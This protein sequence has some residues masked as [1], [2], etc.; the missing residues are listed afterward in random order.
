MK[1]E[2]LFEARIME[3]WLYVICNITLDTIPR[4]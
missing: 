2:E 4:D 1:S 3:L